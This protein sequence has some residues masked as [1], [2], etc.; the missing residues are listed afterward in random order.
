MMQDMDGHNTRCQTFGPFSCWSLIY[1]L[2]I[3]HM[4]IP[5]PLVKELMLRSDCQV[6]VRNG[7]GRGAKERDAANTV[8]E[9]ASQKEEGPLAAKLS[10]LPCQWALPCS[11]AS[12]TMLATVLKIELILPAMFGMMAPAVTATKPAIRAYSMRS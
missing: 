8:Q 1:P 11:E 12:S 9:M 3:A 7:C 4:L 6:E 10:D 5:I 2:R